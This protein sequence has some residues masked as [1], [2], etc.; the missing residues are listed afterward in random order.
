VYTPSWFLYIIVICTYIPDDKMDSVFA[1]IRMY[2]WR[3]KKGL[4]FSDG[5]DFGNIFPGE[6]TSYIAIY[7]MWFGEL[8][9]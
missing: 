6:Q 4:I 8:M 7:N 3:P 1:H 2:T 5:I 9:L